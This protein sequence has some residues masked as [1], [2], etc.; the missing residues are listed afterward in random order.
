MKKHNIRRVIPIIMALSIMIALPTIQTVNAQEDGD[1]QETSVEMILEDIKGLNMKEDE[2][3]QEI[4]SLT[5]NEMNSMKD[6]LE[7]K[8]DITVR[9]QQV[10]EIIYEVTYGDNKF[11]RV[12]QDTIKGKEELGVSRRDA[13]ELVDG[14]TQD[15][16]FE[17]YEILLEKREDGRTEEENILLD[18]IREDF[19]DKYMGT[20]IKITIAL[21]IAGIVLTIVDSGHSTSMSGG[22]FGIVGTVLLAIGI[23][24]GLTLLGGTTHYIDIVK[25]FN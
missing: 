23:L 10:L 15:E 14:Y 25:F 24:L 4:G 1:K 22:F 16:K 11:K 7:E 21:I 18:A 8:P 12:E 3:R 5:V 2:V 9:E 13:K 6:Y 17:I 19:N 20:F